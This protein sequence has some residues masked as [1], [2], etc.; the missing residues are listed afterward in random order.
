MSNTEETAAVQDSDSDECG[1]DQPGETSVNCDV[2]ALVEVLMQDR[3]RREEEIAEDRTRRER[4]ME[5][6]VGEMKEQMETMYV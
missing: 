4:E 6:R 3:H 5:R 1:G 2:T